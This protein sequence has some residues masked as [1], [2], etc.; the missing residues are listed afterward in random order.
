[1]LD[2]E[3]LRVNSSYAKSLLTDLSTWGT[4]IITLDNRFKMKGF[5]SKGKLTYGF[6]IFKSS[7]F[8]HVGLIGYYYFRFF[9]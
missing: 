8:G 5:F 1:M 7:F 2:H 4:V 3:V 6:I 9:N